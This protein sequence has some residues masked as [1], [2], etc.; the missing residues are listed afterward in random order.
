MILLHVTWSAD[1]RHPLF[2]D[3]A[4]RRCAVRKLAEVGR[5]CLIVFCLVDEHIHTALMGEP[6]TLD[7]RMRAI[8]R[9]MRALAVV[10]LDGPRVKVI[11]DR[12]HLENVAGYVLRQPEHHGLPVH[13]ALWSGGCVP[14]L[15]GA[16]LVPGLTLRLS[17]ALPR[18]TQRDVLEAVGL[19]PRRLDPPV[20]EALR[21]LGAGALYEAAC[22]ALCV[23]PEGGCHAAGEVM[24][25]RAALALARECGMPLAPVAAAAS[26]PERS[27]RRLAAAPLPPDVR[28]AVLRYLAL[29]ARV[30][31]VAP[32]R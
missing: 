30:R 29:E 14:D 22:A 24:A 21:L 23:V 25:R 13:S 11:E 4:L 5:D 27:A 2:P 16:R 12:T 7:R 6:A 1:G 20:P 31:E 18:H 26:C 15:M 19:P 9:S 28:Q 32:G 8:L 10:P 3:E 17:D